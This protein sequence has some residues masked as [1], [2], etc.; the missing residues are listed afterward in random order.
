MAHTVGSVSYLKSERRLE[1][2]AQS[3]LTVN[4]FCV[5]EGVSP[6][7]FCNW[8][9]K[10]ATGNVAER[11]THRRPSGTSKCDEPRSTI[12]WS[13]FLPLQV[14]SNVSPRSKPSPPRTPAGAAG[15]PDGFSMAMAGP[16][17]HMAVL[18]GYICGSKQRIRIWTTDFTDTTD[19]G[20]SVWC[21]ICA[22]W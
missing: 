9:K 5:W 16:T 20:V 14:A 1:R 19:G 11:V 6:A 7:T 18:Y 3:Q 2:Y 15:V 17:T 8:R 22:I 4:E 21:F 13:A 10:L 12:D